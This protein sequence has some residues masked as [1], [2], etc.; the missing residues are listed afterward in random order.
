MPRQETYYVFRRRILI[1]KKFDSDLLRDSG[2]IARIW[3][4]YLTSLVNTGVTL[5]EVAIQL[6]VSTN[7]VYRDCDAFG[8]AAKCKVTRRTGSKAPLQREIRQRVL[9]GEI[10]PTDTRI[11]LECGQK[12]PFY[13]ELR[14]KQLTCPPWLNKKCLNRYRAK[15][16]G[17]VEAL[18]VADAL[19]EDDG[20]REDYRVTYCRTRGECR[21][22]SKC[23]D[24]ALLRRSGVFPRYLETKGGCYEEPKR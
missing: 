6:G 21:H 16:R 3:K 7:V 18:A 19:G 13:Q 17:V 14:T 5:E 12:F 20:L 1:E 11:C 2:S 10:K 15:V 8:I 9:S 23:L 24:D 22:Y 4:D